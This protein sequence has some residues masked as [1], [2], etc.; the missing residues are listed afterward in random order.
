MRLIRNRLE[1]RRVEL[2]MALAEEKLKGAFGLGG[3]QGKGAEGVVVREVFQG[4]RMACL[5]EGRNRI[6][7]ESEVNL[8]RA[9][10]YEVRVCSRRNP[11][12][13]YIR[14]FSYLL[15]QCLPPKDIFFFSI[16]R[17]EQ[18]ESLS[19]CKALIS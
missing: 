2:Q 1:G 13:G 18:I 3:G 15:L 11:H 9:E 8:G 16:S 4:W 7:G 10:S 19:T 6:K 12:P 14:V 5:S 17:N